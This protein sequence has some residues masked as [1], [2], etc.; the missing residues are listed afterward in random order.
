MTIFM[1]F[2]YAL[3]VI[4]VPLLWPALQLYGWKRKWLLVVAGIGFLAAASEIWQS[5]LPPNAIRI[6]ALLFSALLTLLYATAAGVLYSARRRGAAA[7]LGLVV[8]L[9][10]GGLAYQWAMAG[11]EARRLTA[12]LDAR[13][14]LLFHAK[15]RDRATY[16]RAFGP[17]PPDSVTRPSGHWRAQGKSSFTRLIINGKGRTWLFYRCGGTECAF[18]PSGAGLKR[19]VDALNGEIAWR[20][21]LRPRMGDALSMRILRDGTDGL[22]VDARGQTIHFVKAPPP[23][24]PKPLPRSLDFVGSFADAACQGAHAR[25]RQVWLWRTPS[26]LYGVGVFQTLLA[27]QRA[28]FVRP[29]VMGKGRK[30]GNTWVFDWQREGRNES[31]TI[32]LTGGAVSLK[33]S[34]DGGKPETATLPRRAIFRDEAIDFAP[35]TTGADWQHWFETVLTGSFF[36]ADIPACK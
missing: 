25:V 21:I 6:D 32:A 26:R 14:A 34:R 4:W 31:A 10:G 20:T 11:R 15:F 13:N 33:L 29:A 3:L 22:V 19:S 17:F 30:D 23:I 28:Q 35:L 8:L 1:L 18:G 2:Y 9:V 24:N 5:F 12:T 27:G 16:E 7:L 36:S